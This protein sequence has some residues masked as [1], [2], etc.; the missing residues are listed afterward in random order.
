VGAA[1]LQELRERA[2]FSFGESLDSKVNDPKLAPK[3]KYTP[4]ANKLD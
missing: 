1:S 4:V 3:L 2:H